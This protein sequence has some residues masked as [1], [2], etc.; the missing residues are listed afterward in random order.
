[1]GR[2]VYQG[3]LPGRTAA[4]RLA[5]DNLKPMVASVA[6]A[7]HLDPGSHCKVNRTLAID[8]N[9]RQI[10]CWLVGDAATPCR[11]KALLPEITL[12]AK[13]FALHRARPRKPQPKSDRSHAYKRT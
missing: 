6:T 4:P 3:S 9:K 10:G 5:F 1:M 7:V 12:N 13:K 11:L 8:K 2:M